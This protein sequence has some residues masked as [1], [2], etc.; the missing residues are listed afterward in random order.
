MKSFWS[1]GVGKVW[2]GWCRGLGEPNDPPPC[3]QVI[4]FA[5]WAELF[6]TLGASG[7][8]DVRNLWAAESMEVERFQDESLDSILTGLVNKVGRNA[9]PLMP[10]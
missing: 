5:E 2:A 6:D 10:H 1:L 9:H 7:V 3:G 4:G 8:Q